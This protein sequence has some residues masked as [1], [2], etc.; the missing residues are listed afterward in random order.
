[1]S[2][3]EFTRRDLAKGLGAAAMLA[4]GKAGAAQGIIRP[5]RPSTHLR[6]P[7]GFPWGP[8]TAAHQI[9]GAVKADGRGATNWDVFTHTPGRVANGDTGDVADDSYHLFRED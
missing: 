5:D 1:M 4:A 6:F 3:S 7:E 8:A 2:M 9:E